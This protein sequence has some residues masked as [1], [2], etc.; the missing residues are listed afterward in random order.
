MTTKKQFPLDSSIK[1][2]GSCHSALILRKY[3]NNCLILHFNI[4]LF[5]EMEGVGKDHHLNG[6]EDFSEGWLRA[7]SPNIDLSFKL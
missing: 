5:M 7:T 2:N 4:V 3:L 1:V 6:I